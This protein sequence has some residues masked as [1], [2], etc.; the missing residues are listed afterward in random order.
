MTNP[1]QKTAVQTTDS[2]APA[3]LQQESRNVTMLPRHWEWL[4]LQSRSASGTLRLLIDDARRDRDGAYRVR[5]SKEKCYQFM[6]DMAGNR[7]HFEEAIRALFAAN[8]ALFHE[9]IALWPAAIRE[10]ISILSAPV[11]ASITEAESGS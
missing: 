8:A 5:E 3:R 4:A 10:E 6:R 1:S 7:P 2:L 9:K 11:W